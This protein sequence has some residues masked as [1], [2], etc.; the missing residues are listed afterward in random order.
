MSKSRDLDPNMKDL[1]DKSGPKGS[2]LISFGT[3][4]NPMD[5]PQ[6]M[7]QSFLEAISAFPEITFIWKFPK[8]YIPDVNFL[9]FWKFLKIQKFL[10][11]PKFPKK[12]SKKNQKILIF[13]FLKGALSRQ[14][15]ENLLAHPRRKLVHEGYLEYIGEILKFLKFFLF[16]NFKYFLKKYFQF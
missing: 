2:V 4:A 15:C 3:V 16:N 6:P 1:L 7:L 12:N 13:Q 11:N 10:K 14:F 8:T 9:N 5:M